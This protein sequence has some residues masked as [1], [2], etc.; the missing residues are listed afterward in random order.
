[1]RRKNKRKNFNPDKIISISKE[2]TISCADVAM[3]KLRIEP[4]S[5]TVYRVV[6]EKGR[7]WAD[8]FSTEKDATLAKV[9]H[10]IAIEHERES[11]KADAD[12]AERKAH[13]LA[14]FFGRS[15]G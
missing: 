3:A 6:D 5:V 1:M 7:V 12:N 8:G 11:V 10:E 13:L 14:R 9:S 2:V 4:Y 15:H